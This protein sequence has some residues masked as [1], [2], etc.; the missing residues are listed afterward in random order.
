MTAF[1]SAYACTYEFGVGIVFAC[2]FKFG[3]DNIGFGFVSIYIAL[4]WQFKTLT[5]LML[6][7]IVD[8]GMVVFIEIL[9]YALME[10]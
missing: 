2:I 10:N 7:R 1:G 9:F 6:F 8:Y 4:G 3:I 5:S